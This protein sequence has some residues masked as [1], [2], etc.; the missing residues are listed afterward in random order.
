MSPENIFAVVIVSAFTLLAVYLVG[1]ASGRRAEK[2]D[3]AKRQAGEAAARQLEVEAQ[4]LQAQQ[5]AEKEEEDR[6][7]LSDP[8]WAN[9][10]CEMVVPSADLHAM[11]NSTKYVMSNGNGSSE[12]IPVFRVHLKRASGIYLKMENCQHRTVDLSAL[13]TPEAGSGD[14][15]R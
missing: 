15:N 9:N 6:R 2:A 11:F 3:T 12:P 5:D 8:Q 13:K 1:R 10:P 14:N 4:E 7:L